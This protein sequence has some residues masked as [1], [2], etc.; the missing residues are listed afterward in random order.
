MNSLS[1]EVQQM[2]ALTCGVVPRCHPSCW[3]HVLVKI[4][5]GVIPGCCGFTVRI[6]C[7]RHNSG[8]LGGLEYL[9]DS[10]ITHNYTCQQGDCNDL[11]QRKHFCVQLSFK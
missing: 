3:F 7:C 2:S 4:V 9:M 5:G 1:S 11:K 8:P 10:Q 6:M